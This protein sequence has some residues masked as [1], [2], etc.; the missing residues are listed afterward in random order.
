MFVH[1]LYDNNKSV[2][3]PDIVIYP[4]NLEQT[5]SINST[6]FSVDVL[7]RVDATRTFVG[8]GKHGRSASVPPTI[9]LLLSVRACWHFA[10]YPVTSTLEHLLTLL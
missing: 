4:A 8:R 5:A 6:I 7:G 9:C 1:N 3:D 10:I 2:T